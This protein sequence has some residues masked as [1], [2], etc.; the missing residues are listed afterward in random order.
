[1]SNLVMHMFYFYNCGSGGAFK[2]RSVRIGQGDFVY[3]VRGGGQV[4]QL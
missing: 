1:M 4:H 3:G 2:A